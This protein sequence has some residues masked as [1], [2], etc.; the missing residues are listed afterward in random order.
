M[1]SQLGWDT[2]GSR[3]K[4][5]KVHMCD[6]CTGNWSSKLLLYTRNIN[7]VYSYSLLNNV[8]SIQGIYTRLLQVTNTRPIVQSMQRTLLNYDSMNNTE[9]G[10]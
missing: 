8:T 7:L 3:R 10:G 9:T 2:L 4:R 1:T 5:F 6:N